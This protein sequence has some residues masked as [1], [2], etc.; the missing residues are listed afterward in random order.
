MSIFI[1]ILS[2]FFN[3]LDTILLFTCF[4]LKKKAP[5]CHGN[6][7][8]RGTSSPKTFF[9]SKD[10]VAKENEDLPEQGI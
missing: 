8:V 7:E 2:I 3:G 4:Q 10:P 6:L 9:L 1:I 5:K